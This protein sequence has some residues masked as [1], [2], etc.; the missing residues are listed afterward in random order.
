MPKKG[1][2]NMKKGIDVSD[3]QG[4]IDWSKVKQSGIEFVILRT[5]RKSGNPDHYLPSNIK[6]C[7]EFGLPVDF[8]KYSYALT[9]SEAK[10][11]ALRVVEVLK[12]YGV[13][14][15]KNTTIWMDVED[16]TQF[17][18]STKALTDIVD[19]WKEIIVN[20]GFE[21]GL[22]MGKYGYEHEIDAGQFN[23]K[24]WIARYYDANKVFAPSENPNEKYKP[25]AKSGYL[26]G[27][28]YSSKGNVPGIKGNVDMDV[29]YVDIKPIE[30]EPQY[31]TTPEFTLIDCLNKI[32][33]DSSYN[34][35]KKI[36]IANGIENYSGTAPQNNEILS[37]L[38]MG[39]LLKH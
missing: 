31:Y 34:N 33:V 12:G 17:S 2:Y 18:L 8:Y 11:E 7:Y 27:W 3:C 20:S 15:S 25:S 39:K 26:W 1:V 38:L 10:K 29:S 6:A 37:L 21:F 28:Q 13:V 14:P 30:V 24:I 22:Y 5:T 4:L 9:T 16:K 36:A 35:R 32:G 23:D 19:V